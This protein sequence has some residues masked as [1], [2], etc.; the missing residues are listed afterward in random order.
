MDPDGDG[1]FHRNEAISAV[2]DVD[3][4]YGD[5]DDY[6]DLYNDVNVGD[7]F[8]QSS[9]PPPQPPPP[10]R[11]PLLPPTPPP[12]PPTEQPMPTPG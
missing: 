12:M 3:Q 4:Y 5:D 1:S 11:Q 7:G 8:L 9:H 6:D 10:P 2:Q